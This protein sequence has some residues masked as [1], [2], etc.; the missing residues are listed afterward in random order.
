MGQ[1]FSP[2]RWARLGRLGKLRAGVQMVTTWCRCCRAPATGGSGLCCHHGRIRGG[3]QSLGWTPG[4]AFLAEPG[5]RPSAR[6]DCS[7]LWREAETMSDVEEA[8]DKSEE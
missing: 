2:G 7:S 3:G 4:P 6:A 5:G 8:V 1:C